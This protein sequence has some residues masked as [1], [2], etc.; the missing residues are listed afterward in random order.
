MTKTNAP[1]STGSAESRR[2]SVPREAVRTSAIGEK[3]A[4][5]RQSGALVPSFGVLAGC[6][7]KP[8]PAVIAFG[9]YFPDW[10]ILAMAAV[11]IAILA[12][13]AFGLAGQ[14]DAVPFPL[15]T[16]LA[17]GVIVTSSLYLFWFG[18]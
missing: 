18:R 4:R 9:A 11:V 16:C 15:F 5:R 3:A 17:I 13:I 12:R 7:S 1:F 6:S 8:A 10:L 2:S 14:G